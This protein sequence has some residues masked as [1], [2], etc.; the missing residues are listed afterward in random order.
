MA[1]TRTWEQ[2]RRIMQ[3]VGTRNTGPELVVRQ[4]IHSLGFKYRLHSKDLPGSPDVV[5][6]S[7]KKAI[8]VHGCFW[9]GHG[10][11]KGKAPKSKLEYWLPKL[12]ANKERDAAKTGELEALGWSV[13]TLW[14]CELKDL[15]GLKSRILEFLDVDGEGRSTLV[16]K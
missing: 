12:N 1:D 5:L 8:F 9:H 7:R 6:R 13:L 15:D 3:S 10:C 16:T 11:P 2:R 14:Q 4:M